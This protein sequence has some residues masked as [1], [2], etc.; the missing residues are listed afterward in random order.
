MSVCVLSVL[1]C[2]AAP[3]SH[4]DFDMV[5]ITEVVTV[6]EAMTITADHLK[7]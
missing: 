2:I 7:V 1:E 3:L 4:Q 6:L 5:V